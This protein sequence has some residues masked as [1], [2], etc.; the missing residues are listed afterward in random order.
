[1]TL[2]ESAKH[3]FQ[4]A[5]KDR[6]SLFLT[7]EEVQALGE[8][9]EVEV[10]KPIARED[11]Y[12]LLMS[13]VTLDNPMSIKQNGTSLTVT[14][15]VFTTWVRGWCEKGRLNLVGD[16]ALLSGDFG[17]VEITLSKPD[18]VPSGRTT[19][20]LLSDRHESKCTSHPEGGQRK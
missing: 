15:T 9:E 1:M 16:S 2:V 20:L 8:Y 3:K 13:R 17:E 19:S 4:T 10:V 18:V 7:A 11:A 6:T 12:A 14:A 5:V